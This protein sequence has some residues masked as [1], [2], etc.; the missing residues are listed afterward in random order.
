MLRRG[1]FNTRCR[2]VPL[3]SS[4]SL[5]GS[6]N[7]DELGHMAAGNW[8]LGVEHSTPYP[9]ICLVGNRTLSEPQDMYGIVLI[10]MR[11]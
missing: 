5:R 2:D 4:G 6:D 9:N 8:E 1:V 10:T 3:A 7:D 11:F